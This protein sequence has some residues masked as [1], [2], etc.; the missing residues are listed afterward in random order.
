[1][2]RASDPEGDKLSFSFSSPK[3]LTGATITPYGSDGS[4]ATFKWTPLM[5]DIGQVPVDFEVTDG[6]SSVTETVT[7][8]VQQTTA[9][10]RPPEFVA[11]LHGTT[12]MNLTMTKCL[13]VAIMVKD[14]DSPKVTF[15]EAGTRIDGA[16][17]T[18][19]GDFS[20]TWHW[21]PSD[22]QIDASDV[23]ILTVTASDG[24]ATTPLN[25][26]I[27][28]E[29]PTMQNCPGAAPTIMHTAADATTSDN[30][31]LSA[32]ISDDKGFK[33]PPMLYY[34]TAQ[35]ASPVDITKLVGVTMKLKSGDMMSGT[36]TAD[37]PNPAAAMGSAKLYYVIVAKDNDDPTGGCD[38]TTQAPT[39]GTYS[40]KVTNPGTPGNLPLCTACQT[41]LQCG[42]ADD[43]CV[44]VGTG[45]YC[46]KACAGPTDC[47]TNYAC[48]AATTVT[49]ATSMQCKPKT[50]D[51][52]MITPPACVDDT[53]EP[54]DTIDQALAK[55][56]LDVATLYPEKSCPQ[57]G[58]GGTNPDFYRIVLAEDAEITVT[59]SGGTTSDL[60]LQLLD[61]TGN[62][63]AT[64]AS[65]GSNE[66]VMSCLVAGT[67]YIKVYASAA[68]TPAENSYTVSYSGANKSCTAATCMPDAL[69]PNDQIDTEVTLDASSTYEQLG[70]TICGFDVD[71]FHLKVLKD[72]TLYVSITF[73][74]TPG[75]KHEDLDLDIWEGNTD[76]TP[77]DATI[78]CSAAT[79]QSSDSNEYYTHTATADA[80]YYIAVYGYYSDVNM[81]YDLCIST[82]SGNCP[83]YP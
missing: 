72:Q 39:T 38:H 24:M 21:C 59:L 83:V 12:T 50:N 65:N 30:V 47:P 19:T 77:C 80:D 67:Y 76:L 45:T 57:T 20:A 7:I 62:P 82:E 70:L 71:W 27:V 66:S 29:R 31:T 6:G 52:T 43:N 69:E 2:L 75:D 36:W 17:L 18:V 58:G 28:L 79:G 51:C 61:G 46:G 74:Q 64:S 14:P 9:A 23:Y 5:S 37:V 54:N 3:P 4:Q 26:R 53:A 68:V 55:P 32:V 10:N 1:M 8:D 63:L 34:A 25:Y 22:A 41:D 13:D 56:A 11:P 44:Q 42:G 40:M 16:K 49:G 35:P 73:Q 78:P 15:A 60:D 81:T 33:D 48:V